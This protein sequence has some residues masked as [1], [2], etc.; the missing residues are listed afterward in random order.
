MPSS[1]TPH[2]THHCGAGEVEGANAVFNAL[3]LASG[4]AL[5]NPSTRSPVDGVVDASGSKSAEEDVAAEEGSGSAANVSVP[6]CEWDVASGG[7]FYC[8]GDTPFFGSSDSDVY[9][10]GDYKA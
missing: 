6:V 3:A 10:C 5:A 4:G 8:S 9:V 2:S 7:V 1:P